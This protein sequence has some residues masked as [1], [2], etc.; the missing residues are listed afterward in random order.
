ML[1]GTA[2]LAAVKLVL[3]LLNGNESPVWLATFAA[4]TLAYRHSLALYETL[5]R[6]PM[7]SIVVKLIKELSR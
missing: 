1:L 7:A 6:R 2:K 4:T 3:M 5:L